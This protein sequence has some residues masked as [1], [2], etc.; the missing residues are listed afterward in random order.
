MGACVGIRVNLELPGELPAGSSAGKLGELGWRARSRLA[1]G[2]IP[3]GSVVGHPDVQTSRHSDVQTSR[4]PDIQTPRHPDIQTF[5][6]S[7]IQTF[8]HSD[9][10]TS[11]H[12][13]I[14]NDGFFGSKI[15][16]RVSGGLYIFFNLPRNSV[17]FCPLSPLITKKY[18]FLNL[19][20]DALANLSKTRR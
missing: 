11:R 17:D 5:R 13:D 6:H 9:I 10:Q 16:V 8:R 7:D 20:P 1:W 15:D 2:S 4:H 12:S 14:Q 3:A 19:D 18:Y